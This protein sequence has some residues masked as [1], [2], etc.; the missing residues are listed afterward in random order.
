MKRLFAWFGQIGNDSEL[1]AAQYAELRKQVPLLYILLTVNAVVLSS[2]FR[3]EDNLMLTT[4]TP[5]LLISAIAVRL[6]YWRRTANEPIP[7]R[8]YG[9]R[10][11]WTTALAGLLAACYSTWVLLLAGNG[12][13]I[14][15][16]DIALLISLTAAGCISCLIH[17]PQ[18]ATI[19]A[20]VSVPAFAVPLF[21]SHDRLNIPMAINVGV[22]GL[23]MMHVL[24]INF[25]SFGELVRSKAELIRRNSETD[26][27]NKRNERLAYSDS[28]TELPNRRYFYARL[29]EMIDAA[30]AHSGT[31][32]VGVL[33][34]DCFKQVND[35]HGHLFGDALLKQVA[36]RLRATLTDDIEFARFGG[37]EF[38]LLFDGSAAHCSRVA[39]AVSECLRRPIEVGG[40]RVTVTASLGFATFPDMATSGD[41]LLNRADRA[42]YHTKASGRSGHTI[43]WEDLEREALNQQRIEQALN[44]ADLARELKLVFQPIV[45]LNS[46]KIVAAEALLR[47]ESPTIGEIGPAAFIPLAE[48]NGL[49]PEITRIV[50]G[51]AMACARHLPADVALSLNISTRDL[52]SPAFLSFLFNQIEGSDIPASRIWIEITETAVMH[53]VAAAVAVL[54]QLRARGIRIA[55]DDFGTG[56]SSLSYLSHLPVDK[57]K[58]DRSFVSGLHDAVNRNII[59][60][61]LVL[62]ESLGVECVVEGIETDEQLA[63]FARTTC[64]YAQGFLFSRPLPLRQFVATLARQARGA[65]WE[66]ARPA[67]DPSQAP[68]PLP[69]ML[70]LSVAS[71]QLRIAS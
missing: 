18:A 27:L 7:E 71:P 49:I 33:D 14:R 59:Q 3:R 50:I 41:D 29:T 16:T 56:F 36:M 45:D 21:G 51:Q 4:I 40:A 63:H 23:M 68:A 44:Q 31:I 66:A 46:A 11:K 5:I 32:S 12:G 17:L 22:I 19:V 38:G 9:A 6:L 28:L 58:I 1:A 54:N 69:E 30:R 42:L 10:L 15:Q 47:W 55:L 25:G 57:I 35:L 8:G 24:R 26:R 52:H 53:N 67:A 64:R 43:F 34:L 13:E 48:R 39:A 65:L 70:R 37:D 60:A 20:L 2:A 62:S 61:I